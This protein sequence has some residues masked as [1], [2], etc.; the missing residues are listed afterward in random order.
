MTI[1]NKLAEQTWKQ[2]QWSRSRVDVLEAEK[3]ELSG[4]SEKVESDGRTLKS[5]ESGLQFENGVEDVIIGSHVEVPKPLPDT[6]AAHRALL[7]HRVKS[8]L[9]DIVLPSSTQ[10]TPDM[11]TKVDNLEMAVEWIEN[12]V[13]I[14]MDDNTAKEIAIAAYTAAMERI[15]EGQSTT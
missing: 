4:D 11:Q 5:L 15:G 3:N 8:I 12:T 13:K 14:D 10:V 7:F 9:Q 6:K 1:T 2:L